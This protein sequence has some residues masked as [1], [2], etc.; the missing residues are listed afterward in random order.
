MPNA[1]H[2]FAND[3]DYRAIGNALETYIC[4]IGVS[5]DNSDSEIIEAVRAIDLK[6]GFF[7]YTT[8]VELVHSTGT[9]LS[10]Y[11]KLQWEY[12]GRKKV[13]SIERVGK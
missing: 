7:S 12:E 5:E 13:Y 9:G 4:D 2:L 1:S 11:A 10:V 8:I 3:P 6:Y